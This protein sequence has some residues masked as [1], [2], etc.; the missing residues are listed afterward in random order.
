M[1]SI[2]ASGIV[3]QA[4]SGLML[5]YTR[6][7]RPGEFV[8]IGDVEG[9]VRSIGFL[10]S[11]IETLRNVEISVPNAF[12]AQNVTRNYSRLAANGGMRLTTAVTIGYDTPW[13]QIQAMLQIAADRTGEISKDPAPRVLQTGLQDFYVEY[14]LVVSIPDPRRKVF[15]LNELHAN[16]Q[17]VFNEHGVQ[18]MSPH[19]ESDPAQVKV[20][21]E[22]RW[23]VPPATPGAGV[24]ST[25]ATTSRVDPKTSSSTPPS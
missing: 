16:I 9:T 17:D 1:A 5:M 11:R 12:I 4:V 18:I 10:T 14:T 8:Q 15:V 13:R 20:V 7:L 6:A 24:P 22:D 19:Y 25:T 21:P 23:F 3:N 2:G